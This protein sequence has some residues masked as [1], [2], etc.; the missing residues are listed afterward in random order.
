LTCRGSPGIGISKATFYTSKKKYVEMR[1]RGLRKL[2]QLEDE[3]SR[4]RPIVADLTLNKQILQE[5][6]G[7]KL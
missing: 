1:V 5:V 3:N 2:Q 4:L 6:V 7:K